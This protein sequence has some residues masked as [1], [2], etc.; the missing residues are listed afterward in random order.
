MSSSNGKDRRW[1]LRQRQRQQSSTNNL[2]GVSL[3]LDS[4]TSSSQPSNPLK[5]RAHHTLLPPPPILPSSSRGR[6]S[7]SA[8][9]SR[10]RSLSTI[11]VKNKPSRTAPEKGRGR[12]L[13]IRRL[14]T[15]KSTV[16][17]QEDQEMLSGK[18]STSHRHGRQRSRS[19]TKSRHKSDCPTNT[20]AIASRRSSSSKVSNHAKFKQPA[21]NPSS[22]HQARSASRSR[23][24]GSSPTQD[25]AV[26]AAVS[27]ATA[28]D[29]SR[30]F[31]VEIDSHGNLAQ[32]FE[33][34]ENRALPVKSDDKKKRTFGDNTTSPRAMNRSSSNNLTDGFHISEQ[35][36]GS[37]PPFPCSARKQRVHDQL[38]VTKIT[39]DEGN[40][41]GGTRNSRRNNNNLREF[42]SEHDI[43]A[44]ASKSKS[45][46]TLRSSFRTS[47][48]SSQCVSFALNTMPDEQHKSPIVRISGTPSFEQSH[49]ATWLDIRDKSGDKEPKSESTS[50][51]TKDLGR[52]LLDQLLQ[53][54][55][56]IDRSS[57][58][59]RS[60]WRQIVINDNSSLTADTT[61]RG[62]PA[63][64]AHKE[65]RTHSRSRKA[66]N[67]KTDLDFDPKISRCESNFD[68]SEEGRRKGSPPYRRS[69]NSKQTSY[70]TED[71]YVSALTMD[72]EEFW[73]SESEAQVQ[74]HP[75][76]L[77]STLTIIESDGE[78]GDRSALFDKPSATNEW[79]TLHGKVH[80]MKDL[81]V[82]EKNNKV[83]MILKKCGKKNKTAPL[84]FTSHDASGG[85]SK[86][87]MPLSDAESSLLLH[88]TSRK[89]GSTKIG[90]L[91]HRW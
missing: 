83:R 85:S 22:T 82:S 1:R 8:K 28:K 58:R 55:S 19:Q 5:M 44:D 77:N 33:F 68:I 35:S 34:S 47:Q 46:N 11:R 38:P 71:T 54:S 36:L 63:S 15:K 86:E 76:F 87:T 30:K 32:V 40:K 90:R 42:V 72:D 39:S 20:S 3:N 52:S 67:I 49:N 43:E 91:L 89:E 23:T 12:S 2:R 64:S 6:H 31:V 70:S 48:R 73:T 45:C 62:R 53:V 61:S 25:V 16:Q 59:C 17:A 24:K 69:F 9:D 18:G 14:K 51:R 80:V 66:Y 79:Y 57:G 84:I 7:S 37:I 29:P 27:C 60:H 26:N 74:Q 4:S 50:G 78:D 41:G 81:P 56:P 13:S 75:D 10:G 65:Q 21:D 88:Q